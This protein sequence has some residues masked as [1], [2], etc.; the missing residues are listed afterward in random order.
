MIAVS[1]IGR[2]ENLG[3]HRQKTGA[4]ENRATLRR[5]ERNGCVFITLGAVNR[6]FDFLFD[7]GSLRRHDRFDAFVLGLFTRFTAFRRIL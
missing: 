4:A 2:A 6:H 3:I 5:V 1:V 7:A